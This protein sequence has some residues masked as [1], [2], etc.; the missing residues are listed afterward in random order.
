MRLPS[1]RADLRSITPHL[2]RFRSFPEMYILGAPQ[3]IYQNSSCILWTRRTHT[4]CPLRLRWPRSDD[5]IGIT[6]TCAQTKFANYLF[7]TGFFINYTGRIIVIHMSN[8]IRLHFLV[9]WFFLQVHIFIFIGFAVVLVYHELQGQGHSTNPS[10][11]PG[12]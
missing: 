4:W 5:L 2:V 12:R 1:I 7:T 9:D 6:G 10:V 8:I 11:P 3:N